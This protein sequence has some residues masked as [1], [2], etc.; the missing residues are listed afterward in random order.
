MAGTLH[1]AGKYTGANDGRAVMAA[2]QPSG[3]PKLQPTA[4]EGSEGQRFLA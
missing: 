1:L 3:I 2:V 4:A